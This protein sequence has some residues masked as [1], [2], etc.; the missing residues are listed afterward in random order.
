MEK[1]VLLS[2]LGVGL[3]TSVHAF[4]NKTTT[5][6]SFHGLNNVMAVAYN[7]S[8]DKNPADVAYCWNNNPVANQEVDI[9]YTID[10]CKSYATVI[11]YP[12]KP[13]LHPEGLS[14]KI[15]FMSDGTYHQITRIIFMMD[16]DQKH[17][18][19]EWMTDPAGKSFQCVYSNRQKG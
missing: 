11:S 15:A 3:V 6:V 8:P 16:N 7:G 9:T 1:W 19:T 10:A 12:G 18:E 2:V 17:P 5:S 13:V 14:D 4:S